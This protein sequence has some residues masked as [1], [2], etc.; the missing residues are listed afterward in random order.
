M[1]NT[2]QIAIRRK[3]WK[4]ESK[5]CITLSSMFSFSRRGKKKIRQ[6]IKQELKVR[7]LLKLQMYSF[8]LSFDRQCK[9]VPP[10]RPA[11][12]NKGHSSIVVH[13]PSI[14]NGGGGGR[15]VGGADFQQF[16]KSAA[17]L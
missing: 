17:V 16:P 10:P 15:G 13:L 12:Q 5:L 7:G 4:V 9:E 14:C 1:Q 6:V 8:D 11:P 3:H 2:K